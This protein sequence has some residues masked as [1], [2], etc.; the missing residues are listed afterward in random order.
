MI[1]LLLPLGVS[2]CYHSRGAE[3]YLIAG[4]LRFKLFPREKKAEKPKKEQKSKEKT[5]P[6]EKTEEKNTGGSL[7]D[8]LP[9]VETAFDFLSDF[10]RKLR[11]KTLILHV[12]LAGGD[13]DTLALNYGK[14]N[15]LLGNLDPFLERFFVIKKKDLR[16]GCDFIGDEML[17]YADVKVD[18]TLGR[19]LV[20]VLRYGLR[21]LKQL[22]NLS[23][24]RKGGG[25]T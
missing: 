20:L 25:L 1:L 10:R 19:I 16:V 4:L 5:A 24:L 2:V 9:L 12:A 23:N 22:I 11:V 7:T 6:A 13:P 14:A 18:I 3:I 8:F 15:A 21:A 17:V